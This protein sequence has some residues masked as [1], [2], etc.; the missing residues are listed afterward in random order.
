VNGER[1]GWHIRPL[2]HHSL[3]R[4]LLFHSL[5]YWL[6]KSEPDTYGWHQFI[7]QGR[8]VWDGVRNYQARNNLNAMQLGDQVLFYHSVTNPGV[9]GLAKV[10]R[11]AYPDPTVT[12]VLNRWVVVELE[13]VLAFDNLVSLRQIKA[14]PLLATMALIKQ[15]R[16][17]VMPIRPDAFES[18]LKMGTRQ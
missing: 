15:S 10:V 1:V 11:E 5:N 8:A 13:P 3:F 14:D 18:I 9:V 12:D 17:S 6:V 4:H 16:L 7:H 2:F